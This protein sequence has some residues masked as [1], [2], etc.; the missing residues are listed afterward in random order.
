MADITVKRLDALKSILNRILKR[1]AANNRPQEIRRDRIEKQ[2]D[3]A[4]HASPHGE[5]WKCTWH[6]GTKSRTIIL[7]VAVKVIKIPSMDAELPNVERI[8][9]IYKIAVGLDYRQ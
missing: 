9:N 8:I 4:Q 2:Q 6:S 1:P 7:V 3:K 5:I